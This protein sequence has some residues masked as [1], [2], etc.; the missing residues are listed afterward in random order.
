MGQSRDY[1]EFTFREHISEQHGDTRQ[2][3]TR[4]A[5]EAF[6][7]APHVDLARGLKYEVDWIAAQLFGES[8]KLTT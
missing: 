4:A 2:A 3:E 5:S 7:Y 1:S 6:G 8:R